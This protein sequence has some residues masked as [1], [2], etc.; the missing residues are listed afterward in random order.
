VIKKHI[1]RKGNTRKNVKAITDGRS[2]KY[3]EATAHFGARISVNVREQ[4][5]CELVN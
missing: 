5:T 1:N 4:N 2:S 3:K